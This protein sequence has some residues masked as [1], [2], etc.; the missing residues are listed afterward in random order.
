M[1]SDLKIEKTAIRFSNLSLKIAIGMTL[2]LLSE[3]IGTLLLSR[4]IKNVWFC[5]QTLAIFF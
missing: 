3:Q 5:M 4:F 2:K 1:V